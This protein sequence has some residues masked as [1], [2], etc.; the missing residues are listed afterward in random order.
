MKSINYISS[1]IEKLNINQLRYI[2]GGDGDHINL[3]ENDHDTPDI[4][5]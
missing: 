3:D 5:A 1:R 4:K 2:V